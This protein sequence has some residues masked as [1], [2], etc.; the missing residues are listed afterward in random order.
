MVI[1]NQNDLTADFV[2]AGLKKLVALNNNSIEDTLNQ[3]MIP[4]SEKEKAK[5][6]LQ[7]VLSGNS[8]LTAELTKSLNSTE[9]DGDVL[10]TATK[11]GKTKFVVL[12]KWGIPYGDRLYISHDI[13]NNVQ[14][15]GALITAITAACGPEAAALVAGLAIG[16]AALKLLDR[17]NGIMITQCPPGVGPCVPTPQ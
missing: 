17:G 8:S 11:G 9:Q 2:V 6:K 13:M 12:K 7:G 16:L 1:S 10:L 3:L 15:I 14:D 4:E 5:E